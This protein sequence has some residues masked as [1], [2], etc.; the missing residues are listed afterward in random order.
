MIG[1]EFKDGDR[2]QLTPMKSYKRPMGTI[3]KYLPA[4]G[5]SPALYK[6]RWD[7]IEA[8]EYWGGHRLRLENGI[9]KLRKI[10]NE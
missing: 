4:T 8:C 5:L 2:V 7:G 1:K 3:M 6:V 10:N 9:Q